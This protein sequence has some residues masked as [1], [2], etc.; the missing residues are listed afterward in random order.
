[1]A[2][3]YAHESVLNCIGWALFHAGALATAVQARDAA[4]LGAGWQGSFPTPDVPEWHARAHIRNARMSTCG[5][6][7]RMRT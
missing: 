6:H 1:M 3:V 4:G 2:S 5:T 7:T